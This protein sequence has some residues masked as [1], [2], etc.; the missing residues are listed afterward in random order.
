MQ[1]NKGKKG[2]EWRIKFT[3]NMTLIPMIYDM[4]KAVRKV[5]SQRRNLQS[6]GVLDPRASL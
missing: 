6:N 2:G 5:T 1:I 4:M 3:R